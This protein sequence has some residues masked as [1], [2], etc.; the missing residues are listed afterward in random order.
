M[1]QDELIKKIIEGQP[2][3]KRND[4]DNAWQVDIPSDD[5]NVHIL[6]P[7]DVLEIFLEA[8]DQ[9]GELL[10]K[11]WVDFYGDDELEDYKE[12]LFDIHDVIHAP[13][14]RLVN[15]GKTLEALAYE[16]HYF[17]GAYHFK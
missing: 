12:Y 4:Q 6:I 9:Q 16:W 11:D 5:I 14:F 13:F 1:N 10:I 2:G 15:D 8:R 3:V 17:F 7:D